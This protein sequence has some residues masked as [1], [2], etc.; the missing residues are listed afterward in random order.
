[1][2]ISLPFIPKIYTLNQQQFCKQRRWLYLSKMQRKS[3]MVSKA[4]L[5]G[6]WSTGFRLAVGRPG[7]DSL[8]ESEQIT[9][10]FGIHNFP[11][12]CSAFKELVWR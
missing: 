2:F 12:W 10:K 1:M 4:V 11:A 3:T 9:L 5:T 8:A 6:E 7:F